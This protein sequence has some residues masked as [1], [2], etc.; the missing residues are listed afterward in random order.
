MTYLLLNAVFLVLAAAVFLV[1]VRRRALSRRGVAATLIALA[2]VLVLTAIFDNIMIG[3]GL[4]DYDPD[5]IVGLRI[6]VAP[7]EDFAYPVGAALLLPAVW[8]LLDRHTA[9]EKNG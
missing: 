4:V 6:G 7:I 5:R 1:A 8:A 3:I 2:V 9:G